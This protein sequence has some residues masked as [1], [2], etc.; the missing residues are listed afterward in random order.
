M[1]ETTAEQREIR[2]QA[3]SLAAKLRSHS[4]LNVT[5]QE[6]FDRA[7]AQGE[8]KSRGMVPGQGVES[9]SGNGSGTGG[10][11]GCSGTVVEWDNAGDICCPNRHGKEEGGKQAVE[12][13]EVSCGLEPE[14]K[15][16]KKLCQRPA[17][18]V[19]A[20]NTRVLQD[21]S[22]FRKIMREIVFTVHSSV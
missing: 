5:A 18:M 12:E 7:N 10:G 21:K 4:A 15:R 1:L 17:Y 16:A 11:S 13:H 14:P 8:G 9:G 20:H 19:Y 3:R 6:S 2:E 22:S